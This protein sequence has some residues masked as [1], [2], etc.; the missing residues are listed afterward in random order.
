MFD[1]TDARYLWQAFTRNS[2]LVKPTKDEGEAK[3]Q[4]A[5]KMFESLTSVEKEHT[6]NDAAFA[7]RKHGSRGNVPGSHPLFSK[8]SLKV[9]NSLKRKDEAIQER[10]G[11]L[12]RKEP[13][14]PPKNASSTPSGLVTI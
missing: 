1:V 4:E 12:L 2:L 13:T 14:L 3:L 11:A 8:S 10:I 5:R 9:L 7:W 6:A